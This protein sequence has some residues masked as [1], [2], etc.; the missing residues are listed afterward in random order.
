MTR[1][2][3]GDLMVRHDLVRIHT[4]AGLEKSGTDRYL[5]A[6]SPNDTA[7]HLLLDG[8]TSANH[9]DHQR[10]RSCCSGHFATAT[11][12]R[13]IEHCFRGHQLCITHG[14]LDKAHQPI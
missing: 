10:S 1:E 9:D 6:H 3:L 13:E 7:M 5:S 14:L 12:V 11:Y 2:N 8:K 4:N